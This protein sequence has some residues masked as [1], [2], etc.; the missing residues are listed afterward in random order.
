[1]FEQ[2]GVPI[3]GLGDGFGWKSRDLERSAQ[4][5]RVGWARA[6]V[7]IRSGAHFRVVLDEITYPLRYGW[8]PL[9]AVLACLRERPRDVSVVPI[10]RGAPQEFIELA[11]TV[12]AMTQVKYH[13]DARVPAR[14]G[15]ED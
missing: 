3:I 6:E 7:A 14:L 4:L 9:E 2:L 8:L 12:T 1:M 5:A 10:G 13:F 11:D 15:I